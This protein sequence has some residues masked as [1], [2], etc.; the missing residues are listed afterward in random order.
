MSYAVLMLWVGNT[1]WGL[2]ITVNW[3]TKFWEG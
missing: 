3:Y 2:D 1:A